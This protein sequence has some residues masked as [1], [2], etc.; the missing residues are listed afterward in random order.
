MN[1]AQCRGFRLR[2]KL[3]PSVDPSASHLR[4]SSRIDQRPASRNQ[5]TSPPAKAP[6]ARREGAAQGRSAEFDKLVKAA[7]EARQAERWDEAIALYGQGGQA[8]A[9]LR[10]GLLVSGHGL[11]HARQPP[12]VPRRVSASVLRLAPKNGAGLRV[13]RPVRVR[14]EGVRPFA[15]AP[16]AVAHA[17][18]RRRAR[19]GRHRPLSRGAPDDPRGSVR[20]GAR[21]ARRV[22]RRR[23]R[24]PARDRGDGPRDAA[25][26]APAG[27]GA[28]R[29]GGRWC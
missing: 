7:T 16:A 1:V 22:R 28:A 5:P 21:D 24:Q 2:R 4:M 15:A 19:S 10:R 18:R 11:L 14:P 26:G 8:E 12:A 20:A 29:R 17:R 9:R 3:Q 6:S 13:S 27:R 23:Q 25:H